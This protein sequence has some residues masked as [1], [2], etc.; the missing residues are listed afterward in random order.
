MWF[1]P[2]QGA[3]KVGRIDEVGSTGELRKQK[4]ILVGGMSKIGN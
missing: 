1:K 4:L 2:T 3:E